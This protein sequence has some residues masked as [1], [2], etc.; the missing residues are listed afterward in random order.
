MGA[1][2]DY[3]AD[4]GNGADYG[5]VVKSLVFP[6]SEMGSHWKVLSSGAM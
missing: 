2:M 6:M 5:P 3:G 4:Y 1:G